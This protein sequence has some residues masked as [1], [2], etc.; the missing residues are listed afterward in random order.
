MFCEEEDD[1]DDLE[2]R[3]AVGSAFRATVFGAEPAG[4]GEDPSDLSGDRARPEVGGG[5]R[6][7][8]LPADDEEDV[9]EEAD[10][11]RRS[12]MCAPESFESDSLLLG[13]PA[14][15]ADG[16][17]AA[18]GLAGRGAI[19]RSGPS[20]ATCGGNLGSIVLCRLGSEV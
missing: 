4:P 16:G 5:A 7:V 19:T 15:V 17:D 12:G 20:A 6:T 2:E 10:A 18:L 1:H 13:G 3:L 8:G 9:D 14:G 11:G